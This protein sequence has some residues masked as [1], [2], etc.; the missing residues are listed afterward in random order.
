MNRRYVLCPKADGDLDHQALYFAEH[1]APEVGHSFLL[2]ADH[3]FTLSNLE[4][5][6]KA[7][8]R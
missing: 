6:E 1:A 4:S 8:V 5:I 3:T 2:A 7:L